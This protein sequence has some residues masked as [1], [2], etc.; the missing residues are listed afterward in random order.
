MLFNNTRFSTNNYGIILKKSI[1]HYFTDYK[2]FLL[3][4]IKFYRLK[5]FL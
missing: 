5:I 3:N 4:L 2:I 1:R